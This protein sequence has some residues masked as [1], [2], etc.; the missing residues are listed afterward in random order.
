MW[1]FLFCFEA[2]FYFFPRFEKEPMFRQDALVWSLAKP[3]I[4]SDLVK[5][6]T[7]FKYHPDISIVH[8]STHILNEKSSS[9]QKVIT[10]SFG[11]FFRMPDFYFGGHS[12]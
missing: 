12:K 8:N 1:K 2:Y 7:Y 3:G 6:F 5:V 9:P 4:I 11:I 10:N